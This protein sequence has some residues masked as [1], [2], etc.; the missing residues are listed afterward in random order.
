VLKTF[1][2]WASVLS[3]CDENL[4]CV[5]HKANASRGRSIQLTQFYGCSDQVLLYS[6]CSL[7]HLGCDYLAL[8]V[9]DIALMLLISTRDANQKLEP[10]SV[11]VQVATHPA[12]TTMR[13]R[14][15]LAL[16]TF[17]IIP[18]SFSRPN[19]DP[20]LD[21]INH[22]TGH[23]TPPLMTMSPSPQCLAL[24][25]GTIQC[26]SA[27]FDGGN[28]AVQFLA[29]VAGYQLTK[30]TINGLFC[31]LC[32]PNYSGQER[33]KNSADRVGGIGQQEIAE[34]RAPMH[35]LCCQVVALVQLFS[36]R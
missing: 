19:P 34:C 33:K 4:S 5:I 32:P 23:G 22:L 9:L 27:I 25:Q 11:N 36:L 2:L 8:F 3:G 7:C 30:N 15:H 13:L 35:K 20:Q 18:A 28:P 6:T 12:P 10:L 14:S 26:C 31:E 29:K 16:L 21:L 24:N 17:I 1:P